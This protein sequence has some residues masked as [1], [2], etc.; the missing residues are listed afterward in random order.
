[1]VPCGKMVITSC[2][3]PTVECRKQELVKRYRTYGYSAMAIVVPANS[4][5]ERGGIW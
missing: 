2:R 1:M 4:Q 5:R 3:K